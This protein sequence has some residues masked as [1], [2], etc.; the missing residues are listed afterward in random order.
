MELLL[1][2]LSIHIIG[3]PLMLIKR[4][5]TSP[6][7]KRRPNKPIQQQT[8]I[9]TWI[10][11]PTERFTNIRPNIPEIKE[12]I[13]FD[14]KP[15]YMKSAEWDIKRKAALEAA[16][17][18]CTDCKSA[19]KLEVHHRRYINFGD[20]PQ[21]DLVAVCRDCHETRHIKYGIPKTYEDYM[22]FN[23]IS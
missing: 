6:K 10:V 21:Y 18:V 2:I 7:R 19:I 23:D 22:T 3:I 13:F 8:V 12:V 20:E 17:Y 4:E 14:F 5:L 16:N 15:S 9:P 1:V 11:Q